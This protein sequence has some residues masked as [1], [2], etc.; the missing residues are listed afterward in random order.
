MR[1]LRGAEPSDAVNGRQVI[2]K[3]A[4]MR[5]H[6]CTNSWCH[7]G[8]VAKH[9]RALPPNG[10]ALHQLQTIQV[11][12]SGIRNF[13]H[14]IVNDLQTSPAFQQRSPINFDDIGPTY[15]SFHLL[16]GYGTPG[17]AHFNVQ[18]IDFCRNCY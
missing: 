18:P 8:S 5:G 4:G 2:L 14:K 16:G 6:S 7:C 3:I 17:I 12:L 1:S 9:M 13:V 15:E 10:N 11:T